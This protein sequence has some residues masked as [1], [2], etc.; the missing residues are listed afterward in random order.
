MTGRKLDRVGARTAL[1]TVRE[2]PLIATVV[3]S[4]AVVL[5]VL[6]WVLAG[7]GWAIVTLIVL[8]GLAYLGFKYK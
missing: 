6:A 2:S 4:P 8:G 7:F 1:E 3:F 5:F